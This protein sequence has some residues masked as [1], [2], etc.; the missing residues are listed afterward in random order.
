[1]KRIIHFTI[2]ILLLNLCFLFSPRP[3][4]ETNF[5]GEYIPIN[6][7]TG[8]I[9]NCDANEFL[10]SA[11]SPSA[12]VREN[13]VRQSRPLYVIAASGI[14]YGIYYISNLF[15]SNDLIGLEKS[16]YVAYVCLNFIILLLALILFEKIALI[17]TDDKMPYVAILILSVFIASNFMTKAFF[18]TAHQQMLAFLMPLL[19]IYISIHV[20]KGKSDVWLY[21]LFF[22]MGVGMLA[23]GSFLILFGIFIL[24]RCYIYYKESKITFYT[25]LFLAISC[26][27]FF[28]PTVLWIWF[29]KYIG[30]KYYSHEVVRYHQLVWMT[31]ALSVSIGTFVSAMYVNVIEF[32]K[33]I[34]KLYLFIGL[35]AITVFVQKIKTGIAFEW[36]RNSRLILLNLFCFGCFFVVLGYYAGRLTFTLMPIILCLGVGN[37]G[38]M[39]RNKKVQVALLAIVSIW[40]AVNV[41]SYGPFS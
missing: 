27:L 33:T 14:G 24:Q 15:T 5:C 39:L 7:Y 2:L 37:S 11:I 16:M 38:E 8:F 4:P 6:D 32:F 30:I 17:L 41:L 22:L 31:E 35:F 19:S 26:T 36:N 25:I 21:I 28:M 10:E 40:H 18:W 23:Y 34:H 3:K 13:Y 1:M 12:L 29:L 20:I 9:R